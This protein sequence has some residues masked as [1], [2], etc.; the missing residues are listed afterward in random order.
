ME[1]LNQSAVRARDEESNRR[2]KDQRNEEDNHGTSKFNAEQLQQAS[3]S[4]QR[5]NKLRRPDG[6]ARACRA[7]QERAS[8]RQPHRNQE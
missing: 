2:D 8:Q 7:I 5:M 3:T 4:V 6:E 1:D